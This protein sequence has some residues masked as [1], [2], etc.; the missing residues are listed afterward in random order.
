LVKEI[1]SRWNVKEITIN[2]IFIK[3]V[4]VRKSD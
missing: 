3:I 1:K 2:L 4:L